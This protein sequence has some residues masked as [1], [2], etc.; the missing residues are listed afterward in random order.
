MGELVNKE[1][2]T[3]KVSCPKCGGTGTF[4]NETCSTCNGTGQVNVLNG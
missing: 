2:Q 4:N 1:A 3:T